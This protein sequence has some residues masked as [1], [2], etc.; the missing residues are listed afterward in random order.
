[1]RGDEAG[2]LTGIPGQAPAAVYG[3]A[4]SVVPADHQFTR[5]GVAFRKRWV[6]PEA[7]K[8]HPGI[9]RGQGCLKPEGSVLAQLGQSDQIFEKENAHPLFLAGQKCCLGG[10]CEV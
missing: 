8:A 6:D 5:P 7:A 3:T 1:M 2:L 10:L 4:V 9:G